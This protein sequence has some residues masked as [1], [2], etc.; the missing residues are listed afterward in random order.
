MCLLWTSPPAD[1]C[2]HD[3]GGAPLTH[4]AEVT[5]WLCDYHLREEMLP[6][7]AEGGVYY[8]TPWINQRTKRLIVLHPDLS[9][10]GGCRNKLEIVTLVARYTAEEQNSMG[11][12]KIGDELYHLLTIGKQQSVGWK[13]SSIAVNSTGEP[14]LQQICLNALKALFLEM[15][16]RKQNIFL[17]IHF[18]R[19]RKM[20]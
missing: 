16:W 12:G 13:M 1:D 9:L 7:P 19:S 2:L 6:S 5:P 14:V 15:G 17:Q 11:L 8:S 10:C 20:L 4:P 3:G 18:P